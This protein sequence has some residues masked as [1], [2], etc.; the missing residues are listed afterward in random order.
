MR[1]IITVVLILLIVAMFAS[2]PWANAQTIDQQIDIVNSSIADLRHVIAQNCSFVF[3]RDL[4]RGLSGPDVICLQQVLISQSY[5]IPAGTTGYF[6]I[7][8]LEALKGFQLLHK[9]SPTAGYFG[10]LTKKAFAKL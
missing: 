7:Q 2:Y 8:T 5:D 10:P 4:Y 1:Y 9:I 6:G 3:S